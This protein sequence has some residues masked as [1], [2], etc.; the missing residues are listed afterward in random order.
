MGINGYIKGKKRR[1]EDREIKTSIY[2]IL[3]NTEAIGMKTMQYDLLVQRT[4][5]HLEEIRLN[6]TH[7]R[8]R[9]V[10]NEMILDDMIYRVSTGKDMK[11]GLVI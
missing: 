5:E 1:A 4:G 2:N 9:N 3:R 7:E 6:Y 8:I 11:V 10:L